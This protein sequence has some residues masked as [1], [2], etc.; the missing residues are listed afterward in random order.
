MTSCAKCGRHGEF[1]KDICN[2]HGTEAS[3]FLLHL[4]ETCQRPRAPN[5]RWNR[6]YCL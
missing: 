1:H 2:A 5:V 4:C 3:K 6:K